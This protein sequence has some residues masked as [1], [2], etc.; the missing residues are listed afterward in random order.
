MALENLKQIFSGDWLNNVNAGLKTKID[1]SYSFAD[2]VSLDLS[3]NQYG[4]VLSRF[5]TLVQTLYYFQFNEQTCCYDRIDKSDSCY[6]LMINTRGELRK[7][8]FHLLTD[9]EFSDSNKEQIIVYTKTSVPYC[10]LAVEGG[11]VASACAHKSCKNKNDLKMFLNRIKER[12]ISILIKLEI[13]EE[14]NKEKWILERMV[15]NVDLVSTDLPRVNYKPNG[16]FFEINIKKSRFF[17]LGRLELVPDHFYFHSKGDRQIKLTT[18]DYHLLID[19]SNFVLTFPNFSTLERGTL[20]FNA[21][22]NLLINNLPPTDQPLQLIRTT[23]LFF[24]N[25]NYISRF[26]AEC[27]LKMFA[28][29]HGYQELHLTPSKETKHFEIMKIPKEIS[30]TS[31]QFRPVDFQDIVNPESQNFTGTLEEVKHLQ[32]SHKS[33]FFIGPKHDSMRNI[34]I[35][36]QIITSFPFYQD[37]YPNGIDVNICDN[38]RLSSIGDQFSSDYFHTTFPIRYRRHQVDKFI[39][40]P[41]FLKPNGLSFQ[42]LKSFISAFNDPFFSILSEF[43]LI[44]GFFFQ[45]TEQMIGEFYSGCFSRP[46]GKE[47]I[48][49]LTSSPS[50]ALKFAIP[51]DERKESF[52]ALIRQQCIKA[53]EMSGFIWTK[54]IIHCPCDLEEASKNMQTFTKLKNG[55][56][57]N[58]LTLNTLFIQ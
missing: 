25:T 53:R 50:Y 5:I 32:N 11:F 33:W 44:E 20:C 43:N 7:F 58:L 23:Q 41:I 24:K 19:N 48:R 35:L 6:H 49:Y 21:P 56:F 46:W 12:F 14:E 3:N 15:D 45:Y 28:S 29:I 47:W 4:F 18:S 40:F 26:H 52:A 37:S 31:H 57:K 51:D 36:T 34:E 8:L 38:F 30:S 10:F 2:L 17:T 22:T 27:I 16:H 1:N 13:F 42:G 9:R 39:E 54:N 55:D